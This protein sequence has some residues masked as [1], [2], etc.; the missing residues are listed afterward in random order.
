[1]ITHVT[2]R[3]IP[4]ARAFLRHGS[5]VES[6]RLA[7]TAYAW[8]AVQARTMFTRGSVGFVAGNRPTI[9]ASPFSHPATPVPGTPPQV[10]GPAANGYPIQVR[11]V[12][13]SSATTCTRPAASSG[14]RA[15][16][17]YTAE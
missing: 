16:A 14:I 3:T 8:R 1:F 7:A 12:A 2:G 17:K 6:I 13:V 11:S 10:G 4:R 5:R 9:T 15:N